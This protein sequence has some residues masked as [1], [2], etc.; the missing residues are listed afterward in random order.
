MEAGTNDDGVV[1]GGR[2]AGQDTLGF[3]S[4]RFDGREDEF[5]VI[6][7]HDDHLLHSF[8]SGRVWMGSGGWSGVGVGMEKQKGQTTARKFTKRSV[9]I[10]LITRF[11]VNDRSLYVRPSVASLCLSVSLC[12]GL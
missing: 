6:G 2:G 9:S 7:R 1:G 8:G 12:V 10:G 3:T 4:G 11:G 5:A